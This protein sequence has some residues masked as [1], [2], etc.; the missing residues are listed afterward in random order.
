M[1]SQNNYNVPTIESNAARFR[2]WAVLFR[3][4]INGNLVL[5]ITF[6]SCM[7]IK[8]VLD[9]ESSKLATISTSALVI[10]PSSYIQKC[11]PQKGRRLSFYIPTKFPLLDLIESLNL[12]M[13]N[14]QILNL[15]NSCNSWPKISYFRPCFT[16]PQ[17]ENH[18]FHNFNSY[19]VYL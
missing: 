7:V 18:G 2:Y 1:D 3:V 11:W 17:I 12:L 5:S 6:C 8:V 19:T 16:V 10:G 9:Y 13:R 15:W 4:K 14:S